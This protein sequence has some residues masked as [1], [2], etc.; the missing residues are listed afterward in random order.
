MISIPI[1]RGEFV[2]LFAGSGVVANNSPIGNLVTLT[3]PPGQ[4]VR[5]TNLS[6]IPDLGG[7]PLISQVQLT[8]GTTEIFDGG[9]SGNEP[10]RASRVSIGSYQG[11]T[12][13]VPPLGNHKHITGKINEVFT[14]DTTKIT[15]QALYYAYEFGE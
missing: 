14:V 7:I 15:E 9:I 8:F 5:V 13:S 3:P 4:R 6:T 12:G 1:K 10:D 11:Y 2:A